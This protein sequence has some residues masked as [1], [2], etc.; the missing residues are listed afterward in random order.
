MMKEFDFSKM[1]IADIINE[2]LVD[3][4]KKGASDIHFDPYEDFLLIRIRIDGIL[5]DYAKV[6]NQYR[7]YLITRIKTIAK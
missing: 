1:P 6:P 5:M 2:I 7:D 3:S 4:T